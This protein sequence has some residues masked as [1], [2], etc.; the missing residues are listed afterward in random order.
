MPA[1]KKGSVGVVLMTMGDPPDLDSVL[2]YLLKLFSDPLIVRAPGV[3]RYPLSLYISLKK[4]DTV[5]ARYEAI[6]GGSPMNSIT[7]HQA[8]LLEERLAS[9][10]RF[11]VYV[12]NRYSTPSTSEAYR[13]IKEDGI[14][15]LVAL[16]LYP[17]YSQAIS[18]SSFKEL[19]KLLDKD[20]DAPEVVWIN[21][22]ATDPRFVSAQAARIRKYLAFIP[23][24]AQ[25]EVQVV[26]SAH[27]LPQEF[28]RQGDPYLDEITHAASALSEALGGYRTYLGFQSKGRPG[29]EW[30]KPETE[31][32]LGGLARKGF[33]KVLLVPISFVAENIETLY[34]CD[35]LY[36]DL[37]ASLGIKQYIRA[38]C[39]DDDPAFIDALAGIV[40][41]RL[42]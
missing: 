7:S 13:K 27:S 14:K 21:S 38:R 16:P 41:D 35:I 19:Q 39:L 33:K 12:A 29:M 23:D 8:S 24:E 34:D 18:G 4:L 37:A 17:H 26:F 11:R 32:V 31:E 42:A 2:P 10:G 36:R 1:I 6:N 25:S 30:L 9:H 5:K 15:K 3:V 40:L 28:V 22:I 20:M